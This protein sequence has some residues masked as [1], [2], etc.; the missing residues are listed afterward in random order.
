M[1]TQLTAFGAI[2]VVVAGCAG[3]PRPHAA[4]NETNV[5]EIDVQ[6]TADQV[7]LVAAERER[8][9]PATLPTESELN[10]PHP[11]DFYV[12][13]ALER[14]PEIRAASRRA[15][16]QQE[17]IPQVTAL[18]DPLLGDT[19]WPVTDNS[20]QTASGRMPNTLTLSQQFPW[21]G[22][23]RLRGE[24]AEQQ[25]K[26]ALT[27]LAKAQ[28]KVTEDVKIAYHELQFHQRAIDITLV[29]KGLLRDLRSAAEAR[30]RVGGSQQDVLRA[31]LEEDKIEDR[32][33][34][35]RREL[36]VAQA[37]L[38]KLLHTLPDTQPRALEG[39]ESLSA[40]AELAQL[41][42]VAVRYRPEL[43]KRLHAIMRDQR[44]EELAEL[45]YYPDLVL[46][47]GWQA[48]TT[49]D[50]LSPAANGHDN[51]GFGVGVNLPIWRDKL[52]AGVREAEQRVLE[53][54]RRYDATRDDTFRLIKRLVVQTHALE[55]QIRLF[56][57]QPDGLIPR[58][59]QTLK[60][61]TA[62][63]PGGTVDFPQL[64]DDWTDVLDYRIQL[65]RLEASLGQ[66]LA[67][68]ERV[69]GRELAS[70]KE[71]DVPPSPDQPQQ[72]APE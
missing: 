44:A 29:N 15:E 50:S 11:V 45:D 28:L 64:I 53:S 36:G 51:V 16:A 43:H 39:P 66:T 60:L 56:K 46:G 71:M 3:P 23:L 52:R 26:I 65:A 21:F 70:L 25:T 20:P 40:P 38:A 24:V 13:I 37:D 30:L 2:W 63:Y 67:S 35:L 9:E 55:Q 47:V 49:D 6:K 58:A 59:D 14:N 33:I 22:K 48:V 7:Q 8:D 34:G 72:D 42:E 4:Y 17:V 31:L 54:T 68:L 10:G 1:R 57:N 27:D 5:Q 62:G 19:F 41:Y 12:R 69:V 61:S 18:D 32:L